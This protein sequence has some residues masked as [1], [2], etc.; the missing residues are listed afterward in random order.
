M[1]RTLFILKL[2]AK[3]TTCL[4]RCP[5]PV[6]QVELDSCR[7][8]H[9]D[10]LHDMVQ[11]AEI[12]HSRDKH[13]R[14]ALPSIIGEGVVPL[15]EVIHVELGMPARCGDSSQQTKHRPTPMVRLTPVPVSYTHLRAHET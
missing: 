1:G 13:T 3:C 14:R 10:C 4:D 5:A 9:A 11:H 6:K 8:V 7:S 12:S 2:T 15:P